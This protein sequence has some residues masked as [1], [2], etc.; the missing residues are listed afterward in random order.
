MNTVVGLEEEGKASITAREERLVILGSSLGTVFEWYDFFL[1]G[2]LA[3]FFGTLFFPHGNSAAALLASLATFGAGFAVR[4]IGALVFGRLGDLLGRKQTFLVTIVL[5]GLSTALVGVLPTFEQ[6]GVAAPLMLVS[7][8]LIQGLALGGEYGGAAIYVAEH[9]PKTRRGA[10]TSW[11]QSTGTLGFLLSLGVILACRTTLG[12][13]G[14][15]SWGW[16]LPFLVSL[17]LLGVSAYIRLK[18]HESPV[19]LRMKAEQALSTAPIKESFTDKRNLKIIL[20][21]LF[22]AITGQAVVWYTGQFYALFFLQSFLK[23]DFAT[24]TLLASIALVIGTPMFV[25]FGYVSD[26]IGRKPVMLTGCLLSVL[27]FMPIYEGLM[28]FGNPGLEQAIKTAPVVLHVPAICGDRCD[29]VRGALAS[30]SV[31]YSTVVSDG[32]DVFVTIGPSRLNEVDGKTLESGLKD[33]GYPAAADVTRINKP[34]MVLLLSLLMVYAAMVYGPI[35]AFLVELFPARIRY[36][37]LSLPYHIG[38]G[39]FGGFLPLVS[40][41]LVLSTGNVFAGLYYPIGVA[42]LTFIVG[43]LFVKETRGADIN[44]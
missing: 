32:G 7:L 35:A 21:A 20:V 17:L 44:R 25:I 37:S 42:A 36:T 31:S 33:A 16:R 9:A 27:T 11:I 23:V 8:R 12:E 1:Y 40:S 39:C 3:V 22:G 30:R 24:A 28:H 43:I 4:P 14:F 19:F 29:A 26:Y 2:S 13:T 34:M 18:L 41:W 15:R 6:V 10:R 5:M 38:N